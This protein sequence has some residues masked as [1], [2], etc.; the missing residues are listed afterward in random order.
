MTN[1]SRDL[2]V[3]EGKERM[4]GMEELSEFGS[5]NLVHNKPLI[6]TNPFL[7]HVLPNTSP[8]PGMQQVSSQSGNCFCVETAVFLFLPI[9]PIFLLTLSLLVRLAEGEDILFKGVIAGAPWEANTREACLR[10]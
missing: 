9:L 6:E 1:N 10:D 2:G 5:K 8:N 3:V 7:S 4:S